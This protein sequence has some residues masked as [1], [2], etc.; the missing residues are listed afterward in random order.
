MRLALED[1]AAHEWFRDEL[2]RNFPRNQINFL[3]FVW[4]PSP[5]IPSKIT[6]KYGEDLL[7][8]DLHLNFRQFLHQN[9]LEASS[10]RH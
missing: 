2:A 5:K 4:S 10:G 1:F 9:S 7:V 3:C 6:S 8:F